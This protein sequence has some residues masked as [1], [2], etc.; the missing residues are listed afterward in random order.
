MRGD[1]QRREL[2]DFEQEI[3]ERTENGNGKSLF[4]LFP[5]VRINRFLDA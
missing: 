4:A 3:A 2:K 5:P 1:R